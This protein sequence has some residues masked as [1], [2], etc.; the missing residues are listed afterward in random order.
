METG[1]TYHIKG[2]MGR[3][4]K[5]RKQIKLEREVALVERGNGMGRN[6]RS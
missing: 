2:Q 3:R 5:Q 4:E 1:R 6:D